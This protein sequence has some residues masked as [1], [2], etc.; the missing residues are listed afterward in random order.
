MPKE[1]LTSRLAGLANSLGKLPDTPQEIM[2][3]LRLEQHF[4]KQGVEL[5][6]RDRAEHQMAPGTDEYDEWLDKR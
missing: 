1:T 4:G 2:V 3:Y 6:D 5:A